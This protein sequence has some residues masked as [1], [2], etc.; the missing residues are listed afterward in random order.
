MKKPTVL[1]TGGTGFLGR[2]LALA[3]KETH[4][5][6]LGAR[7]QKRNLRAQEFTGCPVVPLDVAHIESVRDAIV[8]FRPSVVI[9]AAATKFVDL[10]ERQPME[11]IDINVIGSQNVIRAAIDKGVETVI[12][13]STDKASPPTRNTYGL[14]K[15]LMERAFCAM[16]GRAGTKTLC[17]RYGNVAWSTGSV[18]PIWKRMQEETGVIGTT[19][20]EMRRF[21]FT[22]QEAV[23]LVCTAMD[24]THEFQGTV[25]SQK[26]KSAQISDVL[27]VWVEHRG[28]RWERIQDRPGERDDEFLVGEIEA[29]YT[30]EVEIHGIPHYVVSFNE[31]PSE[32]V[33]FGLSSGNTDRLSDLEIRDIVMNPPVEETHGA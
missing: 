17:V 33:L 29:P 24:R 20:P 8:E 5:V 15:A 27:R 32:P 19:G 12:G 28:G 2:R 25:L 7:D 21:F 6:V 31:K 16:N 23:Q 14:S 11:C 1:V 26:M 9:H 22:V 3:L 10:A 13:I 4:D 18:L 30:R